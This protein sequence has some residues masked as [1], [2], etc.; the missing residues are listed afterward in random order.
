[1]SIFFQK[2]E[3]PVNT[4]KEEQS[5]LGKFINKKQTKRFM[6]RN[7]GKHCHYI[8]FVNNNSPLAAR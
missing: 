3:R 2:N 6:Q 8:K 1:M 4:G 7:I 5:P